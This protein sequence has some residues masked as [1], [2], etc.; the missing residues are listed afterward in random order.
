M[1]SLSPGTWSVHLPFSNRPK[2]KL[3]FMLHLKWGAGDLHSRAA[4]LCCAGSRWEDNQGH[5]V[6]DENII[7]VDACLSEWEASEIWLSGR[8]PHFNLF[9]I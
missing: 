2:R 5:C 4:G 9:L 6:S 3:L 7:E 8:M 1:A